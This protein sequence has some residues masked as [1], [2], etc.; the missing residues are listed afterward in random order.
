MA[1]SQEG[2]LWVVDPG[3][4]RI[5][6]FDTAGAYLTNHRIPGGYVMHPWPGGFD[7]SGM[8]YHPGI[9]L[10]GDVGSRFMLVRFDSDMNPVDTVRIPRIDAGNNFFELRSEGGI[11]RY[12]IPFS[13]GLTWRLAPTGH[14]WF[15]NTGD[16]RIYR[17]TV[18]GDTVRVVSREFQPLPVTEEELEDAVNGLE[19]FVRQGGRVDRSRIRRFKPAL[20]SLYIDD[21]NLLWVAPTTSE[22]DLGRLLDVFDA[23]GRYRGRLSLPF[24]LRGYPVPIF[25]HSNIYG[26]TTDE[27]EVP[28]VVV[29]KIVKP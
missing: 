16:Y 25:R 2:H 3:N 11:A 26:V 29:A 28:Y 20:R 7:K 6:V 13:A 22:E 23:E 9:D 21:D 12:R 15:A 18:G 5:S 17:R 8:F 27:F 24:Q 1:W 19:G 10:A 4:M 14:I